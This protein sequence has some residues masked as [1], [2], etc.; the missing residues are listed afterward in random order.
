[1]AVDE[2]RPTIADQVRNDKV[3]SVRNAKVLSS[4]PQEHHHRFQQSRVRPVCAAQ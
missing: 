4:R 3:L 2:L 1:L